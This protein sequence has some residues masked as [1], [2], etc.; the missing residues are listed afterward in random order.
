MIKSVAV[1]L[2]CVISSRMTPILH[3]KMAIGPYSFSACTLR[4]ENIGPVNKSSAVF[5]KY[6]SNHLGY[7]E[8]IYIIGKL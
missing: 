6:L 4:Q 8:V 3:H 7:R 2:G 5:A 1:L